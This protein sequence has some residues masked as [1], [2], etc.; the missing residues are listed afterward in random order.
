MREQQQDLLVHRLDHDPAEHHGRAGHPL[1]RFA[2]DTKAGDTNGQGIL[3]KWYAAGPD[4]D[5]VG[6]AS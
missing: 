6:D 4:G 5:K 3:N 1:Y 2:G